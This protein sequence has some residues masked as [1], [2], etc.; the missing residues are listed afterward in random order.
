[1]MN[2]KL[3]SQ[4]PAVIDFPAILGIMNKPFCQVLKQDMG[5]GKWL[6]LKALNFEIEYFS[7]LYK[8][9]ILNKDQTHF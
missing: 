4:V 6:K 3:K 7:Y 1:M 8:P 2:R 5:L 9:N